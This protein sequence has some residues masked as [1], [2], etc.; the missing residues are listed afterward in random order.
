MPKK[1][2]SHIGG[3]SGI[4]LATVERFAG[5][6]AKVYS[7]DLPTAQKVAKNDWTHVPVDMRDVRA[8]KEATRTVAEENGRV[9]VLVANA[10]KWSGCSLV[11]VDEALY[12]DIAS[13]NIKGTFFAI[14]SV[15]PFMRLQKNGG[16][17]VVV[18]SDQS[19]V[20]KAEQNLYG[21]TKAAV[22]QLAKSCAVEFAPENIRV[23][24][25]CPGTIDTPFVKGAVSDFAKKKNQDPNALYDWLKTAQPFPRLGH[26]DEVAALITTVAKIPFLVG[27]TISIDGGYTAQ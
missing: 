23:N 19:L 20:G 22:L 18:G 5:A 13:I 1:D 8:L 17:I 26:P 12:D 10:G 24:C 11:D 6:G 7:F 4:G 16:A 14:Q 25:V 9:D 15:I 2:P 21:L 27:A 3:N